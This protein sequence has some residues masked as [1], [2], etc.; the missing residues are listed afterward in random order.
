MSD[1]LWSQGVQHARLP[2]PSLFPGVCSNSC[3][4]SWCCYSNFSCH[5]PLSSCP[6]SSPASGPITLGPSLDILSL[7]KTLMPGKSEGR[8]IR[9]W[10]RMRWLCGITNSMDMSLSKLQEIVK[11]GEA[12]CAVVNGVAKSWTWLS[13]WTTAPLKLQLL[14]E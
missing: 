3:P 8:R 10:Q 14:K 11:N 13:D 5:Q 1:S 7:K 4:L 12:W 9:G 6:R 2:C